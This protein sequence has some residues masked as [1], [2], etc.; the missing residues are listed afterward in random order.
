MAQP[1]IFAVL[2]HLLLSWLVIVFCVYF[3]AGWWRDTFPFS[4]CCDMLSSLKLW[5]SVDGCRQANMFLKGSD[6]QLSCFA[7]SIKKW[8]QRRMLVG[9]LTRHISL[10]RHLS[11]MKIWTDAP[12]PACGEEEE[13]SYHFLEKCSDYVVSTLCLKK[14]FPPSNSL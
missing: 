11:V 7:L 4:D 13:T 3:C 6:K 1:N 5:Q 2:C 9:L 10:N 14:K 12:C 8:N